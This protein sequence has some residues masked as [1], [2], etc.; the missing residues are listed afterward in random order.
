ME[1]ILE[2]DIMINVFGRIFDQIPLVI[3]D[4]KINLVYGRFF[5]NLGFG[6]YLPKLLLFFST[7]IC[8]ILSQHPYLLAY[9]FFKNTLIENGQGSH[10]MKKPLFYF[11]CVSETK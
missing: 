8:R 1:F 5:P 4:Y 9:T 2:G 11:T 6:K 10:H 3:L 7:H